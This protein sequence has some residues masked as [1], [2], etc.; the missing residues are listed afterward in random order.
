MYDRI[1]T[2]KEADAWFYRNRAYLEQTPCSAGIKFFSDFYDRCSSISRIRTVLEVGCTN[3]YNLI[4]L[5]K[6][7]GFSACGIDPSS[8]AVESGNASITEQGLQI[9]LEQGFADDL[10]YERESFDMVYLGFCLYQIDRTVIPQVVS[11]AD[12]V[13]R[14]GGFCVITDFDTPVRYLRENIHNA[15]I[16]TCKTDC[17]EYF[18]TYG[19]TVVE[20]RMYTHNTDFFIP[21]VQE[22]LSTQILYKEPVQNIFVKG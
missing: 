8:Q 22:W 17:A 19:Y 11:E 18:R 2:E 12:R 7:Y 4:Y 9:V 6:K 1:N 20:K 16:P 5:N 10:P 14:E 15:G 3:G 21:D 13:L